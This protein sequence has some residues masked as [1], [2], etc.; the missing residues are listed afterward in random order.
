MG[1]SRYTQAKTEPKY[2][3]A[4]IQ[5]SPLESRGFAEE[6]QGDMEQGHDTPSLQARLDRADRLGHN[7]ANIPI[8]APMPPVQRQSE[9]QSED[10][11]TM[12]MKPQIQMLGGGTD[13]DPELESSIQSAQGGGQPL[14]SDIRRSMEGVF[15]ADFSSVRVH[16][17]A[18]ADTLNRSIH[19]QAFTTGQDVFFR[20]GAYNPGSSSG[21]EL[22]AHE[23]TH[24]VQQS[25]GQVS[26]PQAKLTIG[27]PGDQ[28]EQEADAMAAQVMQM[29]EGDASPI[30][31]EEEGKVSAKPMSLQRMK[32]SS[33]QRS[34][35]QRWSTSDVHSQSEDYGLFGAFGME[36]KV[37]RPPDIV[38]SAYEGGWNPEAFFDMN[39]TQK[40]QLWGGD[41]AKYF[42]GGQEH[43][44]W[45]NENEWTTLNPV[46]RARISAPN[47]GFEGTSNPVRADYT[48][49]PDFTLSNETVSVN[50]AFNAYHSHLTQEPTS[51]LGEVG[52]DETNTIPFY[53]VLGSPTSQTITVAF[54]QSVTRNTSTSGTQTFGRTTTRSSEQSLGG[55]ASRGGES[56]TEAGGK[57]TF[58]FKGTFG[59]KWGQQE[60]EQ[61]QASLTEAYSESETESSSVSLQQTIPPGVPAVILVVPATRRVSVSASVHNAEAGMI[62]SSGAPLSAT[63]NIHVPKGYALIWG[64]DNE[65]VD[66][67]RT[68][69]EAIRAM[70]Q[71][72]E[73]LQGEA[74]ETK[75][76]EMRTRIE[77]SR[78]RRPSMERARQNAE[79]SL[80]SAS[81]SSGGQTI[82]NPTISGTQIK[83]WLDGIDSFWQF[84]G[85][86]TAPSAPSGDQGGAGG[87][88]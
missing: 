1:S 85:G 68:D 65:W 27:E 31:S 75:K 8:T 88:Q 26:R 43:D 76:A 29:S 33:V 57:D 50:T 84:A 38:N 61:S 81:P 60:Q 46:P 53:G 69:Y 36:V 48:D 18:Q 2:T 67:L 51:T 59:L 16:T 83:S 13:A 3:P 66:Q 49:R 72:C 70:R 5:A 63:S 11:E 7:F 40:I 86:T 82:N 73:S 62:Q 71:E 21:K 56:P 4:P 28:Y 44:S 78:S 37:K 15:G 35:I 9:M 22:L 23:L 47:S 25:G 54:S 55:E 41:R 14:G 20:S 45:D 80:R 52:F 17:D 6:Q 34:I 87:G 42:I 74:L 24:V 64:Y 77:E 30:S 79:E 10:E 19:A 12:R 39:N 58:G 32:L